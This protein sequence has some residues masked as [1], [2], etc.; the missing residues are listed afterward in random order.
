MFWGSSTKREIQKVKKQLDLAANKLHWVI[1]LC[2]LRRSNSNR[3]FTEYRELLKEVQEAV[4]SNGNPHPKCYKRSYERLHLLLDLLDLVGEATCRLKL[5]LNEQQA[6]GVREMEAIEANYPWAVAHALEKRPYRPMK[7][8]SYLCC[9]PQA[10]RTRSSAPVPP[11]IG[12][13]YHTI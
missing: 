2:E 13:F 12:C 8:T 9:G 7:Q 10:T 3:C 5:L 4:E 11:P 6:A 1:R